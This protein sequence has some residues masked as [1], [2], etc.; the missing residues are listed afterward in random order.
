MRAGRMRGEPLPCDALREAEARTAATLLLEGFRRA[1]RGSSQRRVCRSR[2]RDQVQLAGGKAA[3]RR[4]GVLAVRGAAGRRCSECSVARCAWRS[5]RARRRPCQQEAPAAVKMPARHSSSSARV[6]SPSSGPRPTVMKRFFSAGPRDTGTLLDPV[7]RLATSASGVR[8]RSPSVSVTRKRLGSASREHS[9]DERSWE[10]QTNTSSSPSSRVP[11]E[12]QRPT[13]KLQKKGSSARPAEQMDNTH[14]SAQSQCVSEHRYS[15]NRNE[16][17]LLS[18]GR[19][20]D[21]LTMESEDK[22][23]LLRA[24]H[25]S[26]TQCTSQGTARD[27]AFL[28]RAVEL[29]VK[30][31]SGARSR[32]PSSSKWSKVTE[33]HLRSASSNRALDGRSVALEIHAA[34]P[35]FSCSPSACPARPVDVKLCFHGASQGHGPQEHP[36]VGCSELLIADRHSLIRSASASQAVVHAAAGVCTKVLPAKGPEEAF[37]S[38]TDQAD[39]PLAS[40][41]VDLEKDEMANQDP[42]ETWEA[43]ASHVD[44]PRGSG[45]C[46]SQPA[47]LVDYASRASPIADGVAPTAALI[48]EYGSP[49]QT[50]EQI[51]EVPGLEDKSSLACSPCIWPDPFASD[52]EIC[53]EKPSSRHA[54]SA[55]RREQSQR[56]LP[57]PTAE[58]IE[59]GLKHAT[60]FDV[61]TEGI[62]KLGT[63]RAIVE[64]QIT[65]LSLEIF[66]EDS[67]AE[68]ETR[69][70]WQLAVCHQGARLLGFLVFRKWAPPLRMVVALRLGVPAPVRRQGYGQKLMSWLVSFAQQLPASECGKIGLSALHSAV[71]FYSSF[72]FVRLQRRDASISDEPGDVLDTPNEEQ[73]WMEYRIPRSGRSKSRGRR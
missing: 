39:S 61:R 11:S 13:A 28:E 27:H 46:A 2:P 68:L 9:F 15:K 50:P 17:G 42:E 22:V 12:P 4:C 69:E 19:A 60:M 7:A 25:L 31:H 41:A 1:R 38:F 72:G 43:L 53:Q 59:F 36:D 26:V 32:S 71:G 37:A 18:Q 58:E 65:Q 8:S 48:C 51:S 52:P 34:L 64:M 21:A 62:H 29:S 20:L 45:T 55:S 10:F 40:P 30:A 35:A 67:M 73:H 33:N 16:P 14:S 24:S 70:N 6:R 57:A 47:E 49:M 54:R 66:R 23:A 44:S 63:E 5:S 3:A 56:R